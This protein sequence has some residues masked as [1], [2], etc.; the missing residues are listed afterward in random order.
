MITAFSTFTCQHPSESATS[1]GDQI[2]WS[3]LPTRTACEHLPFKDASTCPGLT[4]PSHT[5]A[6]HSQETF[7]EEARSA[8]LMIEFL[9]WKSVL[10]LPSLIVPPIC[11]G[12]CSGMSMTCGKNSGGGENQGGIRVTGRFWHIKRKR[13]PTNIHAKNQENHPRNTVLTWQTKRTRLAGWVVQYR[14]HR[15]Y[16]GGLRIFRELSQNSEIA[17]TDTVLFTELQCYTNK[18]T[19]GEAQIR[20]AHSLINNIINCFLITSSLWVAF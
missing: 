3:P 7:P 14:L 6:S 5:H 1:G 17:H 8:L 20:M 11:P 13:N 19:Y 9:V 12:L 15:T 16:M 18:Q 4:S 2:P 10:L